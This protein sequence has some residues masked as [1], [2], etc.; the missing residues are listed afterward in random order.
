MNY[1]FLL[2][3]G[4]DLSMGLHT[5]YRDFLRVYQAAP[6]N[7][8]SI[9]AAKT[10]LFDQLG[11]RAELWADLERALGMLSSRFPHNSEGLHQFYSLQNDLVEH[12]HQYFLMENDRAQVAAHQ[13][14]ILQAFVNLRATLREHLTPEGRQSLETLRHTLPVRQNNHDAFRFVTFNYTTVLDQ[15]LALVL[16]ARRELNLPGQIDWGYVQDVLHIHGTMGQ[17]IILGV[18]NLGQI[19]ND[20]GKSEELK[21]GF[22]KPSTNDMLHTGNNAK[23]LDRINWSHVIVMYGLSLGNTD[24]TWWIALCQW[25]RANALHQIIIYTRCEENAEILPRIYL[26]HLQAIERRISQFDAECTKGNVLPISSSQIHVI[27]NRNLFPF[28]L[29]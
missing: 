16:R 22:C 6:S 10:A 7:S 21:L 11:P 2:G 4:F 12:L 29:V 1:T 25:L 17:R 24:R 28:R 5:S 3:N 13:E 8:E 15:C 26:S 18:D 20:F 19:P 27:V 14:E 9:R 23:F